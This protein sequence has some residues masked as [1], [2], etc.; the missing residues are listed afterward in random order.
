M[1]FGNTPTEVE[2]NIT[3]SADVVNN[4]VVKD[5]AGSAFDVSNYEWYFVARDERRSDSTKVIEVVNSSIAQS[6]SG[7]GTTDT[8]TIDLTN[9]LTNVSQGRYYYEIRSKKISG[10]DN[11]VWFHGNLNNGWTV[12]DAR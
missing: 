8:F 3:K 10:G 6:D 11:D 1:V 5:S 7:S 9:S 2:W 12:Q 4:F